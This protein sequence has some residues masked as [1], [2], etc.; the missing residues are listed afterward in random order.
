[1]QAGGILLTG[2]VTPDEELISYTPDPK[3]F[4][5][6]YELPE[7]KMPEIDLGLIAKANAHSNN[8]KNIQNKVTAIQD[9]LY[10]EIVV[11]KNPYY[12]QTSDGKGLMAQ[13]GLI[14][15][16]EVQR[17]ENSKERTDD[18]VENVKKDVIGSHYAMNSSGNYYTR[19]KEG[20]LEYITAF[21]YM[22]LSEE[23]RRGLLTIDNMI[24]ERD[25]SNVLLDSRVLSEAVSQT[26][27]DKV[28]AQWNKVLT[29]LGFDE[30]H[31]Q[32][33]LN[34]NG[35]KINAIV[36]GRSNDKNIRHA[37]NQMFTSLS[38]DPKVRNTLLNMANQNVMNKIS[39]GGMFDL[40]DENDQT[41]KFTT[42]EVQ[43]NKAL[44][45]QAVNQE[46][47]A[48]IL[49]KGEVRS[50]KSQT[51]KGVPGGKGS[52]NNNNNTK[53]DSW[54]PVF[55]SGKDE[56]ISINGMTIPG[57]AM[58]LDVGNSFFNSKTSLRAKFEDAAINTVTT[59]GRTE[60]ISAE[61]LAAVK[62]QIKAKGVIVKTKALKVI[63]TIGGKPFIIQA[64]ENATSEIL[65]GY[66]R[67][68][69]NI[70]K[71]E[72]EED[73][74]TAV[75]AAHKY[76]EDNGIHA[77]GPIEYSHQGYVSTVIIPVGDTDLEEDEAL[78]TTY[79]T[80]PEFEGKFSEEDVKSQKFVT[81]EVYMPSSDVSAAGLTLHNLTTNG[82]R[83][84]VGQAKTDIGQNQESDLLNT[85]DNFFE[86][87]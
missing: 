53:I 71:A 85:R 26:S 46:M 34:I 19:N 82:K 65:A 47:E 25:V 79:V 78:N 62:T 35:E 10:Q 30:S 68:L 4:F 17:A 15:T 58:E 63:P 77:P 57:K 75:K 61:D 52:N 45:D 3:A 28:H 66:T 37:L 38:A 80:S 83:T 5:N 60:D 29:G 11:N 16:E 81:V 36:T 87:N 74:K 84:T 44:F 21:D 69:A 86:I 73:R 22:N 1:M 18:L 50:Q 43:T 7:A 13:M 20:G 64:H 39:S 51:L 42:Q 32:E 12:L 24:E 27:L 40:K 2:E 48:F 55:I 56:N 54:D 8:K 67:F 6:N 31:E 70:G 14:L 41:K 23:E 59:T 9:K 49:S 33:I 72:T 76:L